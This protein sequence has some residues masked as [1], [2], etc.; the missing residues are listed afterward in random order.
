MMFLGTYGVLGL[1]IFEGS[2]TWPE[3]MNLDV[4]PRR[5]LNSQLFWMQWWTF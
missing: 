5:L 2:S 3:R 4:K 1:G